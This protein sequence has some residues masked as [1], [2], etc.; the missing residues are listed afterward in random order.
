MKTNEYLTNFLNTYI[1]KLL[2]FNSITVLSLYIIHIETKGI[3]FNSHNFYMVYIET[4]G[5]E[6]NSLTFYMTHIET[7]GIEFISLSFYIVL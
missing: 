4:K 2:E 5:I 7:K 6:F 3:K 1:E